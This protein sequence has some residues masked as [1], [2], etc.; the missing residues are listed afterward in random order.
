MLRQCLCSW[1]L[2]V[3]LSLSVCV[4]VSLSLSLCVCSCRSLWL[5]C[6]S[7][8]MRSNRRMRRSL[9]FRGTCRCVFIVLLID[10]HYSGG[11]KWSKHIM[12]CWLRDEDVRWRS[13]LRWGTVN[14]TKDHLMIRSE[15]KTWLMENQVK[16]SCFRKC[17]SGDMTAVIL[18]LTWSKPVQHNYTKRAFTGE[19]TQ[20]TQKTRG[21]TATA[22]CDNLD[23][24]I[25]FRNTI[26]QL[27]SV[28]LGSV[29]LQECEARGVC[30]NEEVKRLRVCV[31]NAAADLRGLKTQHTNTQTQM[32]KL[33]QQYHNDCQVHTHTNTHSLS[34]T[35]TIYTDTIYTH[36]H[37]KYTHYTRTLYTFYTY[38]THTHSLSHTQIHTHTHTLSLFAP[39]LLSL[40]QLCAH[41][42]QRCWFPL[43]HT[44]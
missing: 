11:C 25:T 32:N 9:I 13:F 17:W 18:T 28:N 23:C 4:C 3:S 5:W 8:I 39:A 42:L 30:V 21:E 7:W 14:V 22:K 29:C 31:A 40:S 26:Q 1:A 20:N 6:R 15:T 12:Q 27:H 38:T 33:Q 10:R 36:G 34:L 37:Y 41:T 35:H 44:L 16:L 43:T 24:F 19:N 2:F